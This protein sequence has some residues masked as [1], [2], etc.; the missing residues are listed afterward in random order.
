MLANTTLR[1]TGAITG[2]MRTVAT[3]QPTASRTEATIRAIREQMQQPM[4][5]GRIGVIAP[6]REP[7]VAQLGTRQ[8]A[9]TAGGV[10]AG[11]M[12]VLPPPPPPAGD[13]IPGDLPGGDSATFASA[14]AA[15]GG[16]LVGTKC[17]YANDCVE[18]SAGQYLPCKDR[19]TPV[20][21]GTLAVPAGTSNNTALY[22]G[23]GVAA[24]AALFLLK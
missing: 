4:V 7:G 16:K 2:A 17:V 5:T 1:N 24:V 8:P 15:T 22:I 6:T 13:Q 23:L 11:G 21:P 20:T 12:V 3:M 10:G 14:C 19:L 18:Y 9:K